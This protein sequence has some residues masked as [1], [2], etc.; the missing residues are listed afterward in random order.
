MSAAPVRVG[1]RIVGAVAVQTDIS[2]RLAEEAELRAALQFRD[3]ILGVLSHDVRNPLAIILTAA[4]ILE[5]QLK[6]DDEKRRAVVRR[7]AENANRIERMVRD[8][9]DYTRTRQ[10]RGVPI[11]VRDADVL[12]LC[13][14]AVADMQVLHPDRTLEI[15]ASGDTRVSLDPD[16]AAQVIS[17]LLG[18]ALLHGAP[19]APVRITVRGEEKGVV[20]EVHNDGNPIPQEMLSRIFEPFERAAA[21]GK[22][23]GLGLYIAQQIVQAHGGTISVRSDAGDGTTFSVVWPREAG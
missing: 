8:L 23:L 6:G 14:E 19:G 17:N 10:G 1:D 5:R 11:E 13:R 15:T 2:M 20:L 21:D 18:N 9:L 4:A 16:R 3:R 7:I 12:E 22:G